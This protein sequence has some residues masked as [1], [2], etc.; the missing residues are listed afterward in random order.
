MLTAEQVNNT[1]TYLDLR[2]NNISDAGLR[3]VE[4]WL[5]RS[6]VLFLVDLRGNS[7]SQLA[8]LNLTHCL[9]SHGVSLKIKFPELDPC[10]NSR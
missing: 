5:V 4:K 10:N 8:A 7:V 1:L 2:S 3:S 6:V 9:S